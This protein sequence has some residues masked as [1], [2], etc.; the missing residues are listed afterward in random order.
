MDALTNITID[1]VYIGTNMVNHVRILRKGWNNFNT[2][3]ILSKIYMGQFI[4]QCK[5]IEM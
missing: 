5:V 3:N 2:D 1:L 4:L